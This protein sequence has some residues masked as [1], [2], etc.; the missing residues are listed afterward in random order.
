MSCTSTYGY[1][2]QLPYHIFNGS[3]VSAIQRNVQR[4]GEL[5]RH[6]LTKNDKKTIATWKSD[7]NRILHVFDVR[8][9]TYPFTS[10]TIHL[11]TELAVNTHLVAVD[12]QTMVSNIHRTLLERQEEYDGGNHL[13][14]N[15]FIPPM[16]NKLTLV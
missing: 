13:V 5:S 1:Y 15:Y 10:L 9:I 11:Q 6:T 2:A 4:L 8:F 7:L 14:G 3:A 12:T 16:M